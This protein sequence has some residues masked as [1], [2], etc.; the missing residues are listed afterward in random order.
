MNF[1][2]PNSR[3]KSS[4]SSEFCDFFQ[5]VISNMTRDYMKFRVRWTQS[6]RK[7][8]FIKLQTSLSSVFQQQNV[9]GWMVASLRFSPVVQWTIPT[10][11]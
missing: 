8:C 10:K 11:Y 7:Y 6:K 5:F 3:R 9:H 4:T 1:L 2:P